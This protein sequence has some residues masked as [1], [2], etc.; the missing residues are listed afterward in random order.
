MTM[1][2]LIQRIHRCYIKCSIHTERVAICAE[3][4]HALVVY[5][6]LH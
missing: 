1:C 3:Q 2:H 5:R 4:T 6:I